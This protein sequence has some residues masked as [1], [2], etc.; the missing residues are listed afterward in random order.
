MWERK[1]H[2]VYSEDKANSLHMLTTMS[3]CVAQFNSMLTATFPL[4]LMK[5][6]QQQQQQQQN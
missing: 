1:E 2:L 6:S 3:T 4:R 5:I